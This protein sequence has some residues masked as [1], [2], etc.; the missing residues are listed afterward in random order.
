MVHVA[1]TS[2]NLIPD[3]GD[4]IS[5]VVDAPVQSGQLRAQDDDRSDDDADVPLQITTRHI[6]T[7]PRSGS[8]HS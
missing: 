8:P 3:A 1:P 4:L 6:E 7:V 2:G 5:E